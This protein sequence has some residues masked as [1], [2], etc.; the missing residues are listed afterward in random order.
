MAGWRGGKS[1][2]LILFVSEELVSPFGTRGVIK[3]SH[4]PAADTPAPRKNTKKEKVQLLVL[5]SVNIFLCPEQQM[6]KH[7]L[8]TLR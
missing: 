2:D 1:W 6:C 8:V 7:S 4:Q 5:Q 3:M